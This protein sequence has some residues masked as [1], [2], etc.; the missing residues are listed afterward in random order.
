M[1][2]VLR[3][4]GPH[5]EVK[6]EAEKFE[7]GQNE[8]SLIKDKHHSDHCEKNSDLHRETYPRFEGQTTME[9]FEQKHT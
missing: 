1:P 9:V 2:N 5:T 6:E 7:D 8:A 3:C 4:T